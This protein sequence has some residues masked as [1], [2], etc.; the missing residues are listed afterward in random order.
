MFKEKKIFHHYDIAFRIIGEEK[1]HLVKAPDYGWIADPFLIFYKGEVYLFAEIFLYKSERNGV[2]GYAK[3]EKDHFSDWT[4]TMDKHW[5][6]SYPN[7]WCENDKLYMCP[8][9]Y[10]LEEVAIYE[11]VEFPDK[12]KK[13][14]ILLDNVE[15]ADNTFLDINDGFKYMF[16]FKRGQK[17]PEGTGLLYRFSDN[18]APQYKTLSD[19]LRGTR[20]GG[21]IFKKDGKYIRVAQDCVKEYGNALIFYSIDSVWPEYKE[22]EVKRIGINDIKL[23]NSS[24]KYTG[25]HTYNCIDSIEVIDLRYPSSTLEERKASKRVHKVFLNKY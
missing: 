13:K 8:E 1:F 4:V 25:I 21:K 3:W 24:K 2:I 22:H 15:Y 7:V 17:S 12:W 20:C 14:A 19:S 10:Q 18:T 9:S 6:L 11:L 23:E 16:T 5:H